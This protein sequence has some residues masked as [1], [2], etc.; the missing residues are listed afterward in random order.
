MGFHPPAGDLSGGS[1]GQVR[2]SKLEHQSSGEPG[3]PMFRSLMLMILIIGLGF[4]I[5]RGWIMVDWPFMQAD[6]KSL[7]EQFDQR[8]QDHRNP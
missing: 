7:W 4:G 2:R 3:P 5:Q 1:R 8:S 6:L